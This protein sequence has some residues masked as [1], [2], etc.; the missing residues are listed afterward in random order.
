MHRLNY[1]YSMKVDGLLGAE[2][3]SIRKI[4]VNYKKQQIYIWSDID[5]NPTPVPT[6]VTKEEEQIES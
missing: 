6:I 1:M 2:F 5:L 3:L 4:S